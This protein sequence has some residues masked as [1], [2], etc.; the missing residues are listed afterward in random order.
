MTDPRPHDGAYG[1]D[2]AFGDRH[3]L[4]EQRHARRSRN[5]AVF[6]ATLAVLVLLSVL[7]MICAVLFVLC[8]ITRTL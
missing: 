7:L 6:A 2:S 4:P 1:T 8:A 3:E 5:V